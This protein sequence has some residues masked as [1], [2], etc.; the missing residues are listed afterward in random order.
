MGPG[1][2]GGGR[3]RGGPSF[4]VAQE[5]RGIDW[6]ALFRLWCQFQAGSPSDFWRLTP[7]QVSLAL[8]GR[9]RAAETDHVNRA[10]LAYHTALLPRM[11]RPPSFETL[12]RIKAK[13]KV[14]RTPM[15]VEQMQANFDRYFR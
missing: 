11:T 12:A 10:W 15:S 6:A 13:T 2:A 4:G 7:W 1:Q 8:Q 14:D 3:S 9:R 5:K